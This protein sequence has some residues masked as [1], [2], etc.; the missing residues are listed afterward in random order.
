MSMMIFASSSLSSSLSTPTLSSRRRWCGSFVALRRKPAYFVVEEK[1]VRLVRGFTEETPFFFFFFFFFVEERKKRRDNG[2][3]GG[4]NRRQ[5]ESVVEA[6]EESATE[7]RCERDAT[8]KRREREK[9]ERGNGTASGTA[10]ER[11]A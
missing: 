10:D 2:N 9:R 1:M 8:K 7:R 5:A 6:S 4:T 11:S 3:A